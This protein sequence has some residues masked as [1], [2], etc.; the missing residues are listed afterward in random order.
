M[1]P[2]DALGILALRPFH[3]AGKCLSRLRD[4]EQVNVIRHKTPAQNFESFD[5]RCGGQEA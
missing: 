4:D 1:P 2:V 5:L 3:G